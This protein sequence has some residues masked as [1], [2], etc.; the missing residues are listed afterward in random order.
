[1]STLFID[2]SKSRGYT[3]VAAVIVPADAASMRKAVRELVLPGQ[4][5]LH[6]TRE[7]DPRRRAILSALSAL[8]VRAHVFRSGAEREADGREDCLKALV[9]YAH[10]HSH[11][12][13]VLER[14]ESIE[15]ADRRILYRE[16]KARGLSDAVHYELEAPHDEPLLWIPDALAWSFTKGGDWKRRI[17]PMLAGVTVVSTR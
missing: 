13:L 11:S 14:D 3:L 16:I 7:S 15:K 2:E 6:F 9:A 12:R 8:G 17:A 5:R 10:E 1:M 4:R